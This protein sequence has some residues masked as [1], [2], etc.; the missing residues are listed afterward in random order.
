MVETVKSII[1]WSEKTFPDATLDGQIRKFYDEE[2][3]WLESRKLSEL[4]DMFIVA[5]SIGRFGTTEAA[6]AFSEVYNAFR[7]MQVSFPDLFFE[8]NDK[9]KINRERNWEYKDGNYQHKEE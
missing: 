8:I 1:E 2:K 6:A 3:E 9:M 4:A 7:S 5:C